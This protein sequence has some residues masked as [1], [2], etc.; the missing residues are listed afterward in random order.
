MTIDDSTV[1]FFGRTVRDYDPK[2]GLGDAAAAHRLHID[3]DRYENNES[4]TDLL[5]ALVEEP[6]AAEVVALVFGD[7]GGTAEGNNSSAVVEALVS[8]AE[9]LPALAAF[10]LG[11]MTYEDC[12]VSWI[13]QC[14][15]SPLYGAFPRLQELRIRGSTGLSLG[16][17]RHE[18]LRRLTV[19]TGG[20]DEAILQQVLGAEL[21]AL[22]HLEL[23][24]GDDGYGGNVT[25][26]ALQPLLDQQRFPALKYL[27]LRNA[28]FADEIAQAIQSSIVVAGV[29]VL[30]LSLGTMGD[31]GAQALAT[32]P[33]VKNL[34]KLD[35]HHNYLT[36]AG[37]AALQPLG[38]EVVTV[39]QQEEDDGD[40]FVAVSE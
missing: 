13:N 37:I 33:S 40:R 29:D 17:P 19:E 14:D 21:P 31:A 25:M 20:L 15:I 4:A 6:G 18:N 27:G 12:E 7:W 30:D 24:F 8:S 11:D 26:A 36:D 38:I 22:E 28:D 2:S 1:A 39:D 16:N 5:A 3:W 34:K 23:W 9:K 32:A 35:V 10:F